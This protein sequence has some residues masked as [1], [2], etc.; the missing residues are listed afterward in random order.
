MNPTLKGVLYVALGASSYG[1]L[2]TIVKIA[3]QQDFT[4]AEVTLSQFFFGIIVL[5]LLSYQKR[6]TEKPSKK[7]IRKLMIAGTTMGCTSVFYYLCVRYLNASVAVVFLMQSVWIGVVIEVIQ[8]RKPP[9]L[10][11]VAAV[12]L[13]LFGTVLATQMWNFNA[14]LNILGVLFGMMAAISF[15]LTLFSTNTVGT[16]FSP[17]V[18]SLYMLLGGG[19]VVLVFA[20][21]TQ[22]FPY[23]FG[24]SPQLIE[25]FTTAKPI[26]FRIFYTWGVILAT[27]GTILPPILLNKGFPLTG[28]GLGSIVSSIELPVS[29]TFAFVLLSETVTVVQWLGIVV[30]LMAVVLMN[31]NLMRKRN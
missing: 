28:V 17:T 21:F 10:I 19:I 31:I 2:A 4:T 5:F 11:K 20:L 22:I 29:V 26:D 14:E 27:F 8:K 7:T 24:F 23:Y 30:I 25:D 18:R 6:K 1:M 12:L 3:Y 9:A 13:V 15:S 16:G